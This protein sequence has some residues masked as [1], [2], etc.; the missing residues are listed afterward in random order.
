MVS[1]LNDGYEFEVELR[2]RVCAELTA[3]RVFVLGCLLFV[4]RVVLHVAAAVF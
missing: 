3:L 1:N 4:F 2:S